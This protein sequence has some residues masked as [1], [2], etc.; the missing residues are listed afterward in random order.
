MLIIFLLFV[1]QYVTHITAFKTVYDLLNS[2]YI[3]YILFDII[4][5]KQVSMNRKYH[6]HTLQTNTWYH[7]KERQNTNSHKTS[8]TQLYNYSKATN[9]LF[10]IKVIATLEGQVL[11]NKSKE[12]T[13]N[14]PKQWE[15]Q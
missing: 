15:Q 4:S 9:S 11:N 10:P 1:W 12:Q 6:N 13:Q 5:K 14:P 3:R 2:L 7:E 8:E